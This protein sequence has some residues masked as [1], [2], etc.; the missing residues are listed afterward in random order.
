MILVGCSASD[1]EFTPTPL[2]VERQDYGIIT[3]PTPG[4]VTIMTSDGESQCWSG[5]I[6]INMDGDRIRA[7]VMEAKESEWDEWF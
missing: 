6:Y 7:T 3:N 4:T 2:V 5:T 1:Q